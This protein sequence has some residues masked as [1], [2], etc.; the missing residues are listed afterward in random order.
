[1]TNPDTCLYNGASKA[2]LKKTFSLFVVSVSIYTHR[3]QIC[4][5]FGIFYQKSFCT[6]HNAVYVHIY[7]R[8]LWGCQGKFISQLNKYRM[9]SSIKRIQELAGIKPN[10]S[11][12]A[13]TSAHATALHQLERRKKIR[14][15]SAEWF[16]MWFS[17]PFLTKEKSPGRDL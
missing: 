10:T 16:S 6:L 5:P 12:G 14:P 2:A 11:L 7:K 8:G 3:C 9:D 13:E 17:R 15:G 1:M 4:Q